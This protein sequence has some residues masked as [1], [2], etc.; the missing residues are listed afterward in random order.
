MTGLEAWKEAY[1]KAIE[2]KKRALRDLLT[3]R[4]FAPLDAAL[5]CAYDAVRLAR[6]NVPDF[7]V[8]YAYDRPILM[9]KLGQIEPEGA[10]P[11]ALV[12]EFYGDVERYPDV[13]ESPNPNVKSR[14]LPEVQ[15][16]EWHDLDM[17]E[18]WHAWQREASAYQVVLRGSRSTWDNVAT[19]P[20]YYAG[21]YGYMRFVFYVDEPRDV[22][23]VVNPS[24]I[25]C[26][27]VGRVQITK[28]EASRFW[29]R[30]EIVYQATVYAIN[31]ELFANPEV[32]AENVVT[33]DEYRFGGGLIIQVS[34]NLPSEAIG[35]FTVMLGGVTL[36]LPS[37][38]PYSMVL[39]HH[40][41]LIDVRGFVKIGDSLTKPV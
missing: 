36:K 38:E 1:Q 37:L 8:T 41:G 27:E 6:A 23:D 29:Y 10:D 14:I 30:R 24:T 26:R 5:K 22:Y 16:F 19:E 3:E 12:A 40:V 11:R 4:V 9:A 7:S 34:H 17:D 28:V 35:D 20:D 39:W 13:Y 25:Y 18:A 32:R 31:V 15:R 21:N 33:G 2:L